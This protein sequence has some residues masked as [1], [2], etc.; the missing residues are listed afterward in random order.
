MIEIWGKSNCPNCHKAKM[1]CETRNLDYI[2]K[3]LDVDFTREQVM[4]KFPTAR[5]FPQVV[6][7]G[8][9]IGSYDQMT[10]YIEQM[11]L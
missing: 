11:I 8:K 5:V 2:Y 6:I 9:P 10:T 1:F 4:D 3:Q 7:N